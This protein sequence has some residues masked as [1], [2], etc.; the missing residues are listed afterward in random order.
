MPADSTRES[1]APT[2]MPFTTGVGITWVNHLSMPV[3]LKTS[4]TPA[5]VKPADTVSSIENFLAIAT[6]AI[7]C[8]E[9][10]HVTSILGVRRTFIGWTGSGM[11]KATPVKIFHKPEK[12]KVVDNDIELLTAKA[13]ISGSR[14]PRSPSDPEISDKGELRRVATLLA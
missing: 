1:P 2:C 7:A 11:P 12:T 3:T 10:A 5:V 8:E 4:T 6:A 9:S 13:I 14:V